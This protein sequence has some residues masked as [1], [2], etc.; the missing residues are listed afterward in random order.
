[1]VSTLAQKGMAVGSIPVLGEIFQHMGVDKMMATGSLG[2]VMA[3]NLAHSA[4]AV[5]LNP[6]LGAIFSIF[7]SAMTVV[8][9]TW[10]I[11]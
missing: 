2:G 1:M 3:I 9:V 7:I 10:I 5:G 6:V 11:F 8:T 4:R